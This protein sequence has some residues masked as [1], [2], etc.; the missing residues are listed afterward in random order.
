MQIFN[1]YFFLLH[2]S[3][4]HRT[5]TRLFHRIRFCACLFAP[6]HVMLAFANSF[7][8][9][10]LCFLAGSTLVPRD[11]IRWFPERVAY[12]LPLSALDLQQYL[13]NSSALLMV[14]GQNILQMMRRH[15]FTKV[16]SLCVMELETNH[17]SLPYNNISHRRLWWSCSR[18][19]RSFQQTQPGIRSRLYGLPC[20]GWLS[21][22]SSSCCCSLIRQ[23]V[24]A[25]VDSPPLLAFQWVCEG[26]GI[27]RLVKL[28]AYLFYSELANP[29][30]VVL[31]CREIF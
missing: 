26:G 27:C 15:L 16:W 8:I 3:W 11:A 10:L 13:F 4:Q 28:H 31:P 1:F 30:N 5:S 21:W 19:S 2:S 6:S 17:V 22:P 7:S 24:P 9:D 25:W 18:D 20:F 12:P 23:S 14:L 29:T